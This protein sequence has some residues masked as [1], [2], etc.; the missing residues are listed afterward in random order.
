MR[1][2]LELLICCCQRIKNCH[3]TIA[4]LVGNPMCYQHTHTK[5]EADFISDSDD[6]MVYHVR[7]NM[8]G[9][10]DEFMFPDSGFMFSSKNSKISRKFTYFL[11]SCSLM[12]S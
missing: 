9:L 5:N 10:I 2:K 4:M 11:L 7:H 8:H 1:S 12:K 6:R 3:Y